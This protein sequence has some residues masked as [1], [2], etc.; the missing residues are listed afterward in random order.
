MTEMPYERTA[1]H[2]PSKPQGADIVYD[3]QCP[4]CSTYVRF[5]RL[6]EAIGPVTICGCKIQ[7]PSG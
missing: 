3:G 5:T 2:V 6:R 1:M 4:F 7:R